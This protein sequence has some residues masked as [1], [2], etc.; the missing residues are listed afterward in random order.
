MEGGREDGRGGEAFGGPCEGACGNL[1]TVDA[2]AGEIRSVAGLPGEV[3]GGMAGGG[4]FAGDGCEAGGDV[5]G[6]GVAEEEGDGG[7]GEAAQLQLVTAKRSGADALSGVAVGLAFEGGVVEGAA[8]VGR[9]AGG[10]VARGLEPDLRLRL[11]GELEGLFGCRL[12]RGTRGSGGRDELAV[13]IDLRR[14]GGG[15]LGL[16]LQQGAVSG[17]GCAELLYG[18]WGGTGGGEGGRGLAGGAVV[19][20]E[21]LDPIGEEGYGVGGEDGG[22]GV[23]RIGG[24]RVDG[25]MGDW[26][27]GGGG[28]GLAAADLGGQGAFE[29]DAVGGSGRRGPVEADLVADA[30]GGEVGDVLRQLKRWRMRRAGAGA[31]QG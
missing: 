15:G 16:P 18:G 29:V 14:W 26:S 4:G 20:V 21:D 28:G 30:L 23:H 8:R 11:G 6:K 3:D 13:E 12:W 24:A 10:L 27:A 5:G 2:I 31:A 25:K 7:G 22:Q 1:L 19:G 9:L 17:C